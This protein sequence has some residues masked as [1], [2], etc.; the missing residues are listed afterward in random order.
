[1]PLEAPSQAA[2]SGVAVTAS[3]VSSPNSVPNTPSVTASSVTS[4][5]ASVSSPSTVSSVT[6]PSSSSTPVS[7]VSSVTP[8][9]SSV[10][11]VGTNTVKPLFLYEGQNGALC[12]SEDWYDSGYRSDCQ[13]PANLEEYEDSKEAE[14]KA[15][16]GDPEAKAELE[17][18]DTMIMAGH[19]CAKDARAGGGNAG[20]ARGE[21]KDYVRRI[22]DS[23]LYEGL[24]PSQKLHLWQITQKGLSAGAMGRKDLQE[25][26]LVTENC[27]QSGKALDCRGAKNPRLQN[28]FLFAVP[29]L[30]IS[31][32]ALVD[33]S[34]ALG[35][36]IAGIGVSQILLD[37]TKNGTIN[38]SGNVLDEVNAE[39]EDA[40]KTVAG[41]P[42]P[43]DPCNDW[44]KKVNSLRQRANEHIQKRNDYSND[45]FKYD[46]KGYL[47]NNPD[48]A[49]Q[50]KIIRT[51]IAH[52]QQEIDAFNNQAD[53]LERNCK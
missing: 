22:H 7:S 25:M 46:N 48:P 26:V 10:K 52:L 49:I 29:L 8:P 34:L 19:A 41:S 24:K 53:A 20:A 31:A 27:K 13:K 50:Q 40:A 2:P 47:A 39:I 37:G 28:V 14:A 45:P 36:V 5:N 51:R 21:C 38:I 30:V 12:D 32:G 15:K 18:L 3:S 35:A 6:S 33:M 11:P 44:Q 9:V 42:D 4:P 1:M 23:P 17:F 43:N 16:G